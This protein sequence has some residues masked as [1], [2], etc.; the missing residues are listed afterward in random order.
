MPDDLRRLITC[1]EDDLVRDPD[2]P[3]VAVG[4]TSLQTLLDA[5]EESLHIGDDNNRLR[6]RIV[7]LERQVA[8]W[9][10]LGLFHSHYT[11][12]RWEHATLH[13]AIAAAVGE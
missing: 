9:E 7:E 2:M 11:I 6:S 10:R 3:V 1:L 13:D 4:R 12:G 5:A 8:A